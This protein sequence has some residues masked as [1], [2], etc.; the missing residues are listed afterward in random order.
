MSRRPTFLQS[1]A[2]F[3]KLIGV[4]RAVIDRMVRAGVS[5]N[6]VGEVDEYLRTRTKA[7]LGLAE[8]RIKRGRPFGI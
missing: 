7:K 3:A 4:H 8:L 2:R 6:D 1:Q 5:L